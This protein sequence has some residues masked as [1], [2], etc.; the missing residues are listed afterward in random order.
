MTMC[1]FVRPN[2]PVVSQPWSIAESAL[3]IAVGEQGSHMTSTRSHGFTLIELLITVVIV[4][5]LLAIAIP[6][7]EAYVKRARRA[8]A[9]SEMMKISSMQQE[10]LLNNRS[11]AT[12]LNTL[13]YAVPSDLQSYYT[14]SFNPAVDN[15]A[16]PPSYTILFTAT[17][18][19]AS[20]GNLTLDSTGVKTPADKW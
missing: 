18:A 3:R 20:D 9:E 6:S 7:Y 14:A 4:S 2:R 8:E 10:Y 17:G 13:G 12:A 15:S 19:Q 1:P 16:D 11:Y 5:V